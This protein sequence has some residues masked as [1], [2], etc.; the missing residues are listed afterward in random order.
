MS[1]IDIA[2][3]AIALPAVVG[4]FRLGLTARA[5]SWLGL[6]LGLL[7]GAKLA[8]AVV[9]SWPGA[10]HQQALIVS[11]I[12]L[13]AGALAGQFLGLVAGSRLRVSL[14]SR[15]AAMVDHALGAVTGLAG[16]AL[17]C[18][19]LLPVMTESDAW[20]SAEV[21]QSRVIEVVR[22]RLP[23]P[24]DTLAG[25]TSAVGD[26]RWSE[27]LREMGKLDDFD[28][29]P[30]VVEMADGVDERARAAAV[31]VTGRACGQT[32]DGTGFVAGPGLVM[33]NAHVV[34]G[35][36]EPTVLGE[37]GRVHSARIV[38]FDPSVDLAVLAVD[39]LDAPALPLAE[40]ANRGDLGTVYG[41][42]GGKGLDARP[43][44]I[45][46]SSTV[47]APGLYDAVG[48]VARDVHFLSAA[49]VP[50]DSGAPLVT[51]EGEVSGIAWVVV[52]EGKTQ[53]VAIAPTEIRPVL[54]RA[55]ER[56]ARDAEAA[57]PATDCLR[58]S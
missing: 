32:S 1:F 58:P 34:A 21:E 51:T 4:G 5:M 15:F 25:L 54:E 49:L 44:R 41:H 50:G 52:S 43:Y 36:A 35:I 12:V 29:P 19:L 46:V 27:M 2:I 24:P 16:V 20:P 53:A 28:P 31:K 39:D 8:A 3:V 47:G 42:A 7:A 40:E 22:A 17:A 14:P 9:G 33:T 26:D 18:W 48:E 57:A 6:V 13:L 23:E 10:G 30:A 11:A 38:T 55:M 45:V 37:D 56:L